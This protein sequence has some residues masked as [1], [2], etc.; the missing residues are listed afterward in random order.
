MG[1]ALAE[2]LAKAGA[3]VRGYN[4]TRAKAQPLVE[5]G[6][7]LVDSPVELLECDIV[8]TM[9]SDADALTSV[10]FGGDGLFSRPGRCPQILVELSTVSKEASAK[11]RA[12]AAARGTDML[13]VPV[14]GNDVV[15]RAGRLS[16]MASGSRAAFDTVSPYLSNFGP[17][18]TY[19][20]QGD[21]ARIVKI[22]H[23]LYL[24]IAFEGLAEVSLLAEKH[25]VPR[26]VFLD[27]MNKS[28]LGS[29][30]SRYKTP[31]IANLDYTVTFTNTLMRKDLD[32]GLEA[33][34]DTGVALPATQV[35]RD[36]VQ[37][38]I[39]DGRAEADYT[40][41]LDKLAQYA[42]MELKSEK[43]GV[44]DGLS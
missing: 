44:T 37:A 26:H 10:L 41:V 17:N 40:V 18:V 30:F 16:V 14:S 28:V 43:A 31:V 29:T 34:R 42:G 33:A 35:V 11:I 12:L 15:A 4:R 13:V 2:R 24:A 27:V 5:S 3:D 36:I 38:C 19:V 6:V 20:G 9:V 32:L 21:V 22:C 7:V 25:G 1:Y 23:N 39:D 8:F